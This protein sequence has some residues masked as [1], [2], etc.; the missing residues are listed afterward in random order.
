YLVFTLMGQFVQTEVHCSTGRADCIVT[1]ADTVYIF[2]FKL[3]G[4]GSAEEAL[5]QIKE[6][7]YAERYKA[8]SKKIVLIGSSFDEQTR[9]IKDWKVLNQR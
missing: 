3:S 2:E 9:T 6:N 4:N 7:R 5:N 8:D 1:T